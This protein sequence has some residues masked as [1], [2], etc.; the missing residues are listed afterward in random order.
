[1]VDVWKMYWLVLFCLERI[2]LLEKEAISAPKNRLYKVVR[3]GKL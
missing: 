3:K 2:W 1:M